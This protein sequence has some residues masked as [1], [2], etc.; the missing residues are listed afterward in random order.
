MCSQQQAAQHLAGGHRHHRVFVTG[1]T[2]AEPAACTS[3]QQRSRR[4]REM[5]GLPQWGETPLGFRFFKHQFSCTSLPPLLLS[6]GK[7]IKSV[8]CWRV[9]HSSQN[10]HVTRALVVETCREENNKCKSFVKMQ[11]IASRGQGNWRNTIES[12]NKLVPEFHHV[13]FSFSVIIVG[14]R[15]R[16]FNLYTVHTYHT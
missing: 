9:Y 5:A 12:S 4:G 7:S 11:I 13:R 3:Q 16:L 2:E 8:V 10:H 14:G 6:G 15:T 1:A